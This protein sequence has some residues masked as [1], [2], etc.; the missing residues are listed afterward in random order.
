MDDIKQSPDLP[1]KQTGPT[2]KPKK[3]HHKKPA[4]GTPAR[5]AGT[6]TPGPAS[7]PGKI[8]TKG[9]LPQT[10][11]VEETPGIVD[12][13]TAHLRLQDIKPDE[14]VLEITN[15]A[16]MLLLILDGIA[17]VMF[18]EYA[19]LTP[20]EHSMIQPPLERMLKK[21]NPANINVVNQYADPLLLGMGLI[22]WLRRVAMERAER[23]AA[24]PAPGGLEE[25]VK[26][27]PE[28]MKPPEVKNGDFKP[29]ETAPPM[30]VINS[31]FGPTN[32]VTL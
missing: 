14:A 30:E 6:V 18:G 10:V 20:A 13:E 4:P 17:S 12:P 16:I 2:V 11:V 22:A 9:T 32:K 7:E 1:G 21:L 15:A 19:R 5:P 23:L 24:K 3:S 8:E 31:F 27:P 29:E 28:V 26:G 25:S